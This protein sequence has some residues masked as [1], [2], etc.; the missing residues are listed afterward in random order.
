MN[1]K[2]ITSNIMNKLPESPR[3]A[4]ILGS[5]LGEFINSMKETISIPYA[6]IPDYP[7]STVSGHA[8]E[9]VFGYII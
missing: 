2:S 5:G 9:W 3:S 7:H 4:V 1:L 8:G 6:D